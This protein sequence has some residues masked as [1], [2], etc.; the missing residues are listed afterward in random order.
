MSE[1]PD[2][3]RGERLLLDLA[4]LVERVA[5][6][7]DRTRP[8]ALSRALVESYAQAAMVLLDRAYPGTTSPAEV[9]HRETEHPARVSWERQDAQVTASFDDDTDAICY[10]GY[11][12]AFSA[13][14]ELGYRI[15]RRAFHGSGADFIVTRA[16]EPDNDFIRLEVSGI[17]QGTTADVRQRVRDKVE[18]LGVGSY[19]RP[20]IAA[21]ARFVGVPRVVLEHTP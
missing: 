14:V 2:Q 21:V 15:P 10:G 20:G 8:I 12:M 7:D 16:T 3:E 4:N 9:A 18:Q 6:P 11:A 5:T 17:F 13:L 1:N 19:R